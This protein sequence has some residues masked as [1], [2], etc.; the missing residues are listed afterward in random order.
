MRKETEN[1]NEKSEEALSIAAL[2]PSLSASELEE[3]AYF[4]NRYLDLIERID[5]RLND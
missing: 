2:Y 1:E 4:L 5:A 3:A